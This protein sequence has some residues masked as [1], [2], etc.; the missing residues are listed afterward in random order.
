[1]SHLFA[2]TEFPPAVVI[3]PV[4]R[5][6]V[7]VRPVAQ[8]GATIL[9]FRPRPERLAIPRAVRPVSSRLSEETA[10]RPDLRAIA[11]ALDA[12]PDAATPAPLRLTRR[13]VGALAGLTAL[14]AGALLW[15][16]H[17]SAPAVSAVDGRPDSITVRSGDTLWSIAATVAPERDPRQVV[18]DL[19]RINQLRSPV[20]VPG[21]LLRTG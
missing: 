21:Q 13:G 19:E 7:P 10:V 14:L 16:A 17:L 20:L 5:G 11:G 18:A 2:A 9:A 12:A 3:P 6:G 1:M 8:Q 15:I 4:A